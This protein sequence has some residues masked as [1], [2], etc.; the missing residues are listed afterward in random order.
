MLNEFITE[1]RDQI[2]VRARARVTQRTA[3]HATK[4]E[5]DAGVPL[6]LT[7]IAA[8]LKE[9]MSGSEED[10]ARGAM[11]ASA[12][13]HG[14]N[15]LVAG[16]TIGQVVHDY[17]DVCQAV[18]EL[19]MERCVPISAAEFRAFNR[20]LDDA[21]AGSVSEYERA[22][23]R[24]VAKGGAESLAMLGHGLRN[25]ISS[26][27]LAWDAVRRGTAGT[28]GNV[29]AMLT[30]SLMQ[31][32][33]TVDRSLTTARLD[34]ATVKLERVSLAA[35]I[36]EEEIAAI[37]HARSHGIELSVPAVDAG[38][39]VTI[40][41]QVL[42]GALSNLLQ[43]AFKFT[44]PQSLVALTVRGFDTSVSIE[45][46]DECGGLPQGKEEELLRDAK[47]AS[48]RHMDRGPGLGLVL[49]LRAVEANGGR[50]RVLNL[51]GKGCR[52]TIE[53]PRPLHS[54]PPPAN[55]NGTA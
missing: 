11:A 44:R 30:R 47:Q 21:I 10:A 50:L 41:R 2:I 26:A 27:M 5:L 36:E 19:A 25:V 18:T 49:A 17:G 1:N 35:F 6:F 55:T 16:F 28:A 12:E 13:I 3:P 45:V 23:D 7:Q 24:S 52:F 8:L 33:E 38:L 53:L 4:H 15:L 46:E 40:D 37:I 54:V 9:S 32:R 42:A 31:L 43:N 14:H 48:A 20:C 51:P 39:V 22:R 29:G 34:A